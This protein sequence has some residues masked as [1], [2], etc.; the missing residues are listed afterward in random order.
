MGAPGVADAARSRF[1]RPE[2]GDEVIVG[3]HHDPRQVVIPGRCTA[4]KHAR[5]GSQPNKNIKSNCHQKGHHVDLWMTR[6]HRCSSRRH[7]KQDRTDDDAYIRLSDQHGNTIMNKDGI[8]I[9]SA[10][11][12]KRG[13]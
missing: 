10:K 9:K 7:V 3:F 5:D 12:V 8:V 4:R 2:P 6:N 1:F 13:Q 11:D